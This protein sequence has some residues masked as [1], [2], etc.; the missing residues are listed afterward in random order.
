MPASRYP[1]AFLLTGDGPGCCRRRCLRALPERGCPRPLLPCSPTCIL[2]A[3]SLR[4]MCMIN[5]FFT[6]YCLIII[7]LPLTFSFLQIYFDF[8]ILG[9]PLITFMFI[10][11]VAIIRLFFPFFLILEFNYIFPSAF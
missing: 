1:V 3:P 11:E 8:E 6:F 7:F 4:Q 2:L 5:G 9:I 10:G